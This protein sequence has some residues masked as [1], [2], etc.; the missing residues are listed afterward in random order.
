MKN[1]ALMYLENSKFEIFTIYLWFIHSNE[2]NAGWVLGNVMM[3]LISYVCHT[4]LFIL[5]SL[6]DIFET[7][8]LVNYL[9]H[10]KLFLFL[11]KNI[12]DIVCFLHKL[13]WKSK[14]LTM[15]R[16]PGGH[17]RSPGNVP[18][19]EIK[20]IVNNQNLIQSMQKILSY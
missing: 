18:K 11:Q 7:S 2:R 4:G 17:A 10:A 19:L 12:F 8:Q 14:K 6:G 5:N 15:N 3:N 1:S 20:Y 13:I 16:V 9:D